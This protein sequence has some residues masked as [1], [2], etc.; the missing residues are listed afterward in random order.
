MK[1][2]KGFYCYAGPW[3]AAKLKEQGITH[4]AAAKSL[5]IHFQQISNMTCGRAK[6]PP[7][8]MKAIA[9][10]LGADKNHKL[11]LV[12]KMIQLTVMDEEKRIKNSIGLDYFS[13]ID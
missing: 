13:Q 5:G 3:L 2:H 11:M 9:E 10:M 7:K 12:E 6:I 8:H 1:T 4:G